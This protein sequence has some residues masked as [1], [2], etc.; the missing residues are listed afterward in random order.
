MEKIEDFAEWFMMDFNETY[1][2]LVFLNDI[3]LSDEEKESAFY[4]WIADE[5][6]FYEEDKWEI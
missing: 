3:K 1:R 6:D 5:Y 4:S 2:I